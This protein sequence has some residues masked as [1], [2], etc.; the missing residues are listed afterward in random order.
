[1]IIPVLRRWLQLIFE[2]NTYPTYWT[3]INYYIAQF[4]YLFI[5]YLF[6]YN[7]KIYIYKQKSKGKHVE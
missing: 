4:N 6:N 5:L 7:K 3:I 1:M 2:F